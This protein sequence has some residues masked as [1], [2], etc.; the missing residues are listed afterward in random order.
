MLEKIAVLRRKIND[1]TL[2]RKINH[3]RVGIVAEHTLNFLVAPY[4]LAARC[5]QTAFT[6]K[7]PLSKEPIP[8]SGLDSDRL[9]YATTSV[10]LC[11]PLAGHA[12]PY[13][14]D[15]S[16]TRRK[17]QENSSNR[18]L[19]SPSQIHTTTSPLYVREEN[20][21]YMYQRSLKDA[22]RQRKLIERY[23]PARLLKK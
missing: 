16:G 9:N 21:P 12:I 23:A 14:V 22:L 11:I 2:G 1:S 5:M 20:D 6:L 17:L 10:L 15:P 19:Y 3:S 7:D 8:T 4:S 13:Y 18:P